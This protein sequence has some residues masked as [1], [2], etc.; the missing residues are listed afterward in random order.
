MET[1][2]VD[3]TSL[4]L[5]WTAGDC[6]GSGDD[7]QSFRVRDADNTV[8]LGGNDL[9]ASPASLTGLTQGE[10][11][12]FTVTATCGGQTSDP[13]TPKTESMG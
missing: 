9:S 8:P 3:T 6:G 10:S 4:T 5:S 1:S 7:T 11:Y 13:S 12:M 2:N